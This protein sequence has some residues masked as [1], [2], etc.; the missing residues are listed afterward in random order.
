[1]VLSPVI[2]E[3]VSPPQVSLPP[4]DIEDADDE[5]PP[6]LE[7]DQVARD[8]S[9]WSVSK[10]AAC[11]HNEWVRVSRMTG[12]EVYLQCRVCLST[13]RTNLEWHSKCPEHFAGGC[14]LGSKCENVH[15]Y[16]VQS[17]RR[18]AWKKMISLQEQNNVNGIL[19]DTNK[20]SCGTIP[21][22]FVNV[23]TTPSSSFSTDTEAPTDLD[24]SVQTMSVLG[25]PPTTPTPQHVFYQPRT[26]QV[27]SPLQQP[28]VQPVQ[29]PAPIQQQPQQQQPQQQQQQQFF[30]LSPSVMPFQQAGF[31]APQPMMGQQQYVVVNVPHQ[32]QHM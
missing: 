15:I 18:K 27:L 5:C 31:C 23:K 3:V 6:L 7:D 28:L 17:K 9:T 30:L 26:I 2:R 14:E 19:L 4:L 24:S 21:H 11:G 16:R 20:S 8:F 1:M 12:T 10:E 22:H 32:A 29:V 25:T 13:W